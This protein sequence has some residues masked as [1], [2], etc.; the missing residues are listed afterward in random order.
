MLKSPSDAAFRARL[1]AALVVWCFSRGFGSNN[2]SNTGLRHLL[3]RWGKLRQSHFFSR[4]THT[5]S[6]IMKFSPRGN[7]PAL[8]QKNDMRYQVVMRSCESVFEDRN[9]RR[10]SPQIWP[11]LPALLLPAAVGGIAI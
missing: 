8:I 9:L 2:N 7:R 3:H 11:H 1:S 5:S 4:E 6:G 10:W